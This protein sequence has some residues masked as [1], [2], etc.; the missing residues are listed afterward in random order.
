MYNLSLVMCIPLFLYRGGLQL[1]LGD[2]SVG[3]RGM[4]D[5]FIH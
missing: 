5:T 1:L 3:E 2:Q 4:M